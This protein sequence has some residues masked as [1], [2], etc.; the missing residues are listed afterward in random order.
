MSEELKDV[1]ERA[2]WTAVQ[3]AIA[4]YA[5]TQDVRAIAAAGIAAGLSVIKTYSRKRLAQLG[6]EK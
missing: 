4:C 6:A 5:V 3:S 1:A 2:I